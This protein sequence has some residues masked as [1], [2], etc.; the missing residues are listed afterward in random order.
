MEVKNGIRALLF[1]G[2]ILYCILWAKERFEYQ[3]CQVYV[4][5][6]KLFLKHMCDEGNFELLYS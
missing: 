5:V 1:V 4:S 2:S 3:R 6:L